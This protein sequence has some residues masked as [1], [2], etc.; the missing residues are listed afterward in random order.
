[1]R[2][3]EDRTHRHLRTSLPLPS[4]NQP[5]R[6]SPRHPAATPPQ[7]HL[8]PSGAADSVAVDFVTFTGSATSCKYGPTAALGSTAAAASQVVNLN[9]WKAVMNQAELTGLAPQTDYF[10]SCGSDADGWSDAVNFTHAPS[11][12]VS[13]GGK[14]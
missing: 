8:T 1:V 11:R 7:I 4:L 5:A 14:K 9:T 10:Y 3:W 13:L 12:Q 6:I 2:G